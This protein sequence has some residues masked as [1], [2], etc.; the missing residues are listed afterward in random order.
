MQKH[1]LTEHETRRGHGKSE[2]IF[3]TLH[4]PFSLDTFIAHCHQS[5]DG[6][7]AAGRILSM[8]TSPIRLCCCMSTNIA[9]ELA[10]LYFTLGERA[11]GAVGKHMSDWRPREPSAHP[12]ILPNK[13]S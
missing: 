11:E 5:G 4:I 1:P 12:S 8:T 7:E 6:V 2:S 9:H 13:Y 3:Y 10:C